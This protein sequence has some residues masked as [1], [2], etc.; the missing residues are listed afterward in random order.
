M[1]I[2]NKEPQANKEPNF[3]S[4]KVMGHLLLKVG[5]YGGF[6]KSLGKVVSLQTRESISVLKVPDGVKTG[7]WSE[8]NAYLKISHSYHIQ[9]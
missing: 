3:K 7:L 9:K 6:A 1:N 2:L 8:E 5:N 4:F